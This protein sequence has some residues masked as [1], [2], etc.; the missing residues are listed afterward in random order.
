MATVGRD[1]A[2][3]RVTSSRSVRWRRSERLVYRTIVLV[4]GI[5]ASCIGCAMLIHG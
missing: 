5:I 4:A 3:A 1:D 2:I